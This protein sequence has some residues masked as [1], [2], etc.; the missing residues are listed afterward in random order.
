MEKPK[1][2]KKGKTAKRSTKS[3]NK[4]PYAQAS[5]LKVDDILKL[6][7]NF[8]NLLA[9]KI[10]NIHRMINDSGKIKPRINITTKSP[11]RKQIIVPIDNDNKSKF[12]ASLNLHITNLNS[13][14]KNIKSEVMADFFCTDQ[15]GIIITMNKVTL[16]LDLQIIENYVKN[17]NHIDSNN[18][19]TSH[20]L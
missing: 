4:Q 18:I 13:I 19:K 14:F 11:S 15:H 7:E 9:K 1:F 8:P 20:L 6:K 12:I 17:T 16:P 10:E 2:F 5:A 3:K